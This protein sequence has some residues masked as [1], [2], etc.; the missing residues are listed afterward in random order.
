MAIDTPN[1]K[2]SQ[3]DKTFSPSTGRDVYTQLNYYRDPGDGSAPIPVVVGSG[4]VSNERPTVPVSVIIRDMTGREDYYNLDSHGFQLVHHESQEKDF[5]DELRVNGAYY[6]EMEQLYKQATGATRVVIFGHRVRR[7]P[8]DWHRLGEGNAKNPGP[9]HRVH[10]DQSYAGAE[11]VARQHLP[12]D[13]AETLTRRDQGSSRSSSSRSSSNSPRRWQIVNAWRPIRTVRKDP[14]AVVDGRS[15]EE[16]DLA[17]ASVMY[18]DGS[19]GA[20]LLKSQTWAVRPAGERHQWF[21][22]REQ[23]PDEVLLIKCFDSLEE[24]GVVR[25]APHCA[26][27]DPEAVDEPSRESVEVRALLFYD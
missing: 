21:F 3:S 17:E 5:V 22:K 10:V 27:V 1:Q 6:T 16:T 9:L 13:E 18:R 14:L 11:L 25:R 23:K 4:K 15:V 2:P 12:A 26:F 19:S 7:G 8:S 20:E 24:E